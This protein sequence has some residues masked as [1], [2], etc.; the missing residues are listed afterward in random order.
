M[1][2]THAGLLPGG[3]ALRLLMTCL[4]VAAAAVMPARAA[5]VRQIVIRP[6]GAAPVDTNSVMAFVSVRPGQNIS[7]NDLTRDVKEMEKSGRFT[8]VAAQ[9]DE[10]PGGVNVVYIVNA[11]PRISRIE[12]TGADE[13]GNRKVRELLE[14]GAGDLVDD[15]TLSFKSIAVKDHYA[16]KYYPDAKLTWTIETDNQT[17]LAVVRVK[18]DEGR[19][20]HVRD[21]RFPG[22]T[23]VK[24]AKLLKAMKQKERGFWSWITGSGTYSPDE[25]E[26]DRETLRRVFQDHGLLDAKIGE[27]VVTNATARHIEIEIPVDE[28]RA[29]SLGNLGLKGVTLFPEPAV[30]RVITNKPGEVASMASIEGASRAVREYYSNRGYIATRVTPLLTP[31]GD[32][33]VVDIVFDVTEGRKAF[34]R[35]VLVRGN[36][37]TKDKVIRRELTVYP[38]DEYSEGKTR[39]S[40]NRLRNLGYFKFV[41]AVPE[42]TSDPG[43]YDLA[44]EVE[45]QRTGNLLVGAGFSSIDNLIGFVELSQG[46]FDLF[47]WPPTGGGQKLKLRGTVGSLRRDV[48]LSF[49]EPWFLNRK[50]SLGVDL[51]QH[52]TRYSSDYHLR[53]TGGDVTLG[54]PLGVYNRVNL[55]YGLQQYDVYDIDDDASQIIK[56]EEGS[57][58]KSSLTLELVRDTRDSYF[59]PTRGMRSSVSAQ[60]AGGPLGAETD[61]YKFTAQASKYWSIWFDHVFNVRGVWSSVDYY[62]DSDRVP[63]FDRLFLGG[64]RTLRGFKYR[65]VGPKDENG[66][67]VGGLTSGFASFEYTIPVV[68]KVRYGLFYDV[69]MAYPEAFENS[70]DDLNSD[71]GMG[72]R[73][74]I[75]GFPMRLDYAWPLQA[76]EFNDR[77]SGRFQ[78]SLGY[79]Y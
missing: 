56:D 76:D 15:A 5:V 72:I 42:E 21:I 41:N 43:K 35:D 30:S 20:A 48:E 46:N 27:P 2:A 78:F 31:R 51:Y 6:Q 36:T 1:S 74:D 17:G 18:V 22:A 29:Y 7:R 52:D 66:E 34:I 26:G 60:F 25:L 79:A 39:N 65:D 68:E 33:G 75:P 14:L 3:A 47:R 55:T 64:A 32:G 54:R 28:G 12:I 19:H 23:S 38:G 10:A 73:F 63:I 58:L 8:F 4:V 69:G 13:I 24:P 77:K 45:E 71:W 50:L 53:N 16:K 9:I 61:L 70:W 59:I 49:I 67:P 57:R 11:K 37:V 40:E 62:G 44:F